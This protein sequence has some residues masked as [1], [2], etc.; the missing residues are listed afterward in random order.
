MR[1]VV[2]VLALEVQRSELLL[3]AQRWC[4][5]AQ[6]SASPHEPG[7]SSSVPVSCP[8]PILM[9]GCT[10]PAALPADG[11]QQL[12]GAGRRLAGPPRLASR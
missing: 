2:V 11:H 4:R 1:L 7:N 12:Q 10:V 9:V 3:T 8:V 6:L 5:K